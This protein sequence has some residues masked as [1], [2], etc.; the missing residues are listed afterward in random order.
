MLLFDAILFIFR[1]IQHC[2]LLLMHGQEGLCVRVLQTLCRMATSAKHSF[3]PQVCSKKW[4]NLLLMIR[5][6]LHGNDNILSLSIFSDIIYSADQSSSFH[7]DGHNSGERTESY[8][9]LF[10]FYCSHHKFSRLH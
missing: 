6:K 7:F 2:K 8:N 5:N 1:L 4:I 9:R 3:N 10:L